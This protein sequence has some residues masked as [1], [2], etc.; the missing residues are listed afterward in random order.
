MR[1]RGALPNAPLLGGVLRGEA[2]G[3]RSLR[4][5]LFLGDKTHDTGAVGCILS[6]PIQVEVAL[7]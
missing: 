7:L 6:G 2:W 3:G 1:L 5:A 4:G